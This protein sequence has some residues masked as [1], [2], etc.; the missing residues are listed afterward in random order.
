MRSRDPRTAELDEIFKIMLVPVSP[1]HP[2][3]VRRSLDCPLK[4]Y[5]KII[6]KISRKPFLDLNDF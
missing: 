6:Y 1:K 3:L 4:L 2:V 5:T